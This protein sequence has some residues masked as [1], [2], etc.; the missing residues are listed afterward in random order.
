MDLETQKHLWN[1]S[2]EINKLFNTHVKIF[3]TEAWMKIAR[4]AVA[5]AIMLVS[6]D[7]NYENVIVTKEHVDWAYN[8]LV[9]L[10]DNPV[11]KLRQFVDEQR[12]YTDID[13]A[14]I[15]DLQDLYL[16]NATMFNFLEMTSG[17]PRAVLRDVSGKS[18]EDFSVVLNE[19][20]RLYLFKWSGGNMIPSERLRKGLAKINRNIRMKEGKDSVL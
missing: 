12:K 14:L 13:E 7:A 17:V 8:F 16:N 11:F 1:K 9:R 20:S 6:T 3:G 10:Y 2:V 18:N 19:M 5:S 4:I 15:R